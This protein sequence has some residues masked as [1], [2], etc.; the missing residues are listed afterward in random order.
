LN[1]KYIIKNHIFLGSYITFSYL[2]VLINT[3]KNGAIVPEVVNLG[4]YYIR[5]SPAKIFLIG[6]KKLG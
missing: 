6:S 4:Y 1:P 3:S 2:Q 5:Q